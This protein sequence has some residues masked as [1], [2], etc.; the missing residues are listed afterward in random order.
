MRFKRLVEEGRDI[1]MNFGARHLVFPG[2][3]EHDRRTAVAQGI[4]RDRV[5]PLADE[6]QRFVADGPGLDQINHVETAQVD[7]VRGE[8]EGVERLKHSLAAV[9]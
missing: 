1:A 4:N 9:V 5:E 3:D 6:R 8:K 2:P 7:A